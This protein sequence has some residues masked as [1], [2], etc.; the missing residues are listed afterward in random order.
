MTSYVFPRRLTAL[1][2]ERL[3]GPRRGPYTARG[4]WSRRAEEGLRLD[5]SRVEFVEFTA[6]ARTLLL[7]DAA[8][9]DGIR[10]SVV[11][12]TGTLDA[13]EQ[14]PAQSAPPAT[15]HV[16]SFNRARARLSRRARHRGDVRAFMRQ[17]GFEDALR[18]RHWPAGSVLIINGGAGP[19]A[20]KTIGGALNGNSAAT[21]TRTEEEPYRQ[22]RLLPFSWVVAPAG[23]QSDDQRSRAEFQQTVVT[24]LHD[25]GLSRTDA[26]TLGQTVVAELVHN[27][28]RHATTHT[29][30]PQPVLVGAT[31]L[32]ADAY[33]TRSND[34]P[35]ELNELVDCATDVNSR[36]VQL[37]VGDS[38]IGLVACLG[39]DDANR[40]EMGRRPVTSDGRAP[41]TA[42]AII[43]RA[44]E[45][46]SDGDSETARHLGAGLWRVARVVQ[47]Y[48]GRVTIRSAGAMAGKLY[49][50]GDTGT[51]VA[52][53]GLSH[54]P[55]TLVEV[56]LLVDAQ[57]LD[58][59]VTIW[60]AARP[61]RT[62]PASHAVVDCAYD[63]LLGI[64]EGDQLRLSAAA[65]RLTQA[66]DE[67]A[68][69]IVTIVVPAHERPLPEAA[70]QNVLR[71]IVAGLAATP[72]PA[73]VVV[74]P[75]ADP[76]VLDVSIAG[77]HA[78]KDGALSPSDPSDAPAPMLI[79]GARGAPQWCGG[80]P[81]LRRILKELTTAGGVLP[82][83]TARD[84]W[85]EER[86]E[87]E[88]FARLPHT[89]PNLVGTVGNQ[90]LLRL[91]PQDVFTSLQEAVRERLRSAIAEGGH[92]VDI[93]TFRTPT[94]RVTNRWIDSGRLVEGTVG[95]GLAAF[96]LARA[97]EPHLESTD[98]PARSVVVVQIPTAQDKLTTQLS[99]CLGL[100]GRR[101]STPGD[102]DLEPLMSGFRIPGDAAAVLCTDLLST[103]NTARR[104]IA[105]VVRANAIPAV[106]ACVVDAREHRRPIEIFNR[107]IPVVSL[108][109]VNI[110]VD[111]DDAGQTAA[112]ADIDP[113][114]HRPVAPAQTPPAPL[115]VLE[116]ELLDWCARDPAV[117][118]L[119]HISRAPRF[120]FSAYLRM[121]RLLRN[122]T[123][124]RKIMRAV[125]TMV[126]EI[127]EGWRAEGVVPAAAD[128]IQ[129][130]YPG[131]GDYAAILA[132]MLQ[133]ELA[134]HGYSVEAPMGVPRGVA[135]DRWA[136]PAA[137]GSDSRSLPV[138]IVDWGAISTTSV[139][140]MI[141][142]AARAGASSI[143]SITLLNQVTDQDTE[144]LQG[145]RS[146][147]GGPLDL[148]AVAQPAVPTA[149]RFVTATSLS[150]MPAHDCGIC[151]TQDR[152]AIERTSA[153]RRLRRHADQLR[154]MMRPKTRDE[155][156]GTV[157]MDLLNVP[158]TGDDIAD[159]LR[160]RG[161]LQR[162]LRV[163]A[164]RHQVLDRLRPE[165]GRPQSST[166][167]H[168]NLLRLLAVE[169]QWLKLPPLRFGW[170]R[171]L[172]A[173]L[174]VT[175]LTSDTL[176]V[177]LRTQAI[178]VLVTANPERFVQLLPD[179][180]PQVMTEPVLVDQLLL[181][182]YRLLQLSSQDSPVSI[183]ELRTGL[184]RCR[185]HLD[186]CV[187]EDNAPVL[188]DH[189]HV[190]KEL[191]VTARY[192]ERVVP[193]DARTA[194]ARLREEL[195][196]AVAAHRLESELLRVRG[197]VENLRHRPPALATRGFD[198]RDDWE[199]C[200]AQ[201]SERAL[202]NLPPLRQILGGEYVEDL[203]GQAN[204]QQLLLL[205]EQ[206][207]IAQLQTV[208]DLLN[209]LIRL[210][211]SPSSAEWQQL[212]KNLLKQ[213]N[214]WYKVFIAAHL[215]DQERAALFVG[216]IGSAPTRLADQIDKTLAAQSIK[217]RVD[218]A[219]I[220][221][222]AE[223]FCPNKLLDQVV[224]H[225]VSNAHRHS[226]PGT[227]RRFA[228]DYQRGPRHT[229]RFVL[230]NTGSK[231]RPVSGRGIRSCNEKLAPF[232][233]DVVGEPLNEGEWTYQSVVTLSLW[234]GA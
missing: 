16:G 33:A 93:G 197:Y 80:A 85:R 183:E 230:R 8:V 148:A 31:L 116:S 82:W 211:W 122:E 41:T 76:R 204:Q 55:G 39:R 174:C 37:V 169:Q 71:R 121:D 130:W 222:N 220:G 155:V 145:Y 206:D 30:A 105:A 79:F 172:L 104:A 101:Y 157:A 189:H 40:T 106:I 34:L 212:H 179:L 158:V 228:V 203:V 147:G 140:Q 84:F 56:D 205:T 88:M 127:I 175:T 131:E 73:V 83:A 113:I 188:S 209:Q 29:D 182:S 225:L 7:L 224:G 97:V 234:E 65:R 58:G 103:E 74:F 201:L 178:M 26:V 13:A 124:A 67:I 200:A 91:A 161:L 52:E 96:V 144:A 118:R 22:R 61:R 1:E 77:V 193:R 98:R 32:E 112:V 78:T 107:S 94:L 181:D 154:D 216:L 137:L 207:N 162:A 14:L 115:A 4:R 95:T 50:K 2:W 42:E 114:L 36:V 195:N 129:I 214:W 47:N 62:Q 135:G 108:A 185:D 192:R 227:T 134:A 186:N 11:L 202:V 43:F 217:A 86:G 213:V 198:P 24:G 18:P 68:I 15:G 20:D 142:L 150:G 159:Y 119:G 165:S 160:W 117:L 166:W 208:S 17:I 51:Y 45:R 44:F 12:P 75:K 229:V 176:S 19:I 128:N 69:L 27:A 70:A 232:G 196:R 60:P 3:L 133:K 72:R 132:N 146:V 21:A 81:P 136:F 125:L 233:A 109:E 167:S 46:S 49:G 141:R 190:I 9:R 184:Q 35:G 123:A 151:T 177:W 156:V 219:D 171:D 89:A 126:T 173:D 168:Q 6:L 226:V 38:G 57:L 110:D 231:P 221:A 25:I 149:V 54:A 170:A 139:Q 163:T 64:T 180:L 63:R 59:L 199:N 111:P 23:G 87:P 28:T 102:L 223:V 48:R 191:I 143:I 100:G 120:H 92:G 194:W 153:P 164:I 152:Y 218:H 10:A 187:E 66:G 138:V 99:E 215:P 90:I 5:F 210:P 53:P